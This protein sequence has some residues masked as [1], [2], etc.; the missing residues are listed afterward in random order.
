MATV[1]PM[2]EADLPAAQRI[3][4]LAFGTFL[5][6]PDP[7]NFWRDRDYIRGRFGAEHV[8]SFAAEQEGALAGSNFATRWGSVGFF[9][10][11]TTRPDLW[12]SGIGQRLVAAV[13]EQ[14]DAWGLRHTGLFTF[15]HST[16]HVGLYGKFGFHPRFLTAIM[17]LPADA[18]APSGK[19]MRYGALSEADRRQSETAA[20]GL[21]EQLYD[22]L[23]LGAEI[24]TVTAR[25][26]GDTVLL[27]EKDSGLGGFAICHWGQ[28]SEAG[29]GCC[30]VKFGAV[31]PGAG[32]AERFDALLDA[33]AALARGVGM[34]QV[35]AGVNTG[36]EEAYRHMLRR[37]FRTQFQG[38]TMH[39]PSETG[40]SRPGLYVLDDWR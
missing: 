26:L 40:Y 31:R 17:A 25:E 28:A 39:R 11:L 18:G 13:C 2:T 19:A 7:E 32:A 5:G 8:A 1:R 6:A 36:R 33:C 34:P 29:E 16:K 14:F 12:D 27:P 3:V 22:G 9:G 30:F 24:R 38:V 37:G 20:R 23:D 15:P 35:L 4:R 21:T 10:P